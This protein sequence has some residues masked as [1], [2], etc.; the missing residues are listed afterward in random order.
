MLSRT[1]RITWILSGSDMGFLDPLKM[2]VHQRRN[3]VKQLQKESLRESFAKKM[4]RVF[5]SDVEGCVTV[6]GVPRD[7]ARPLPASPVPGTMGC[8]G[9]QMPIPQR[10]GQ[11]RTGG[12]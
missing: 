10:V 7:A 4:L 2:T 1:N 11:A 3:R 6:P 8:H 12:Q 5:T 9:P